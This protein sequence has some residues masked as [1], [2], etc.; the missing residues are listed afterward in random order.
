M[1][2]DN[3]SYEFLAAKM[4]PFSAHN[5]RAIFCQFIRFI[6]F[7]KVNIMKYFLDC[8]TYLFQSPKQQ[9][10]NDFVQR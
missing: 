3:I 6:Y 1:N 4:V 5:T 10:S 2:N 9:C 8:L 7:V